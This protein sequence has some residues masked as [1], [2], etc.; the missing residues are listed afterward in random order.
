M[1][2]EPNFNGTSLSASHIGQARS[3][4]LASLALTGLIGPST[5]TVGGVPYFNDLVGGV[6]DAVS[7]R[8]L[9]DV[10]A[11]SVVGLPLNARRLVIGEDIG[12]ERVRLMVQK[13]SVDAAVT[14]VQVEANQILTANSASSSIGMQM[15]VGPVIPTGISCTGHA[16]SLNL[17]AQRSKAL[18][19]GH[20]DE[21]R[22][23]AV[24]VGGFNGLA[25]DTDC[26]E[27]I[28][29]A[30]LYV[31]GTFVDARAIYIKA[32]VLGATITRQWAIQCQDP[33]DSTLAGS[34]AVGDGVG[35]TAAVAEAAIEVNSTTQGILQARMTTA[36]KNALTTEGLIVYD[37]TL[38][39]FY[40]RTDAAWVALH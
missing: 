38:K 37:A 12:G 3:S 25:A 31:T 4:R 26:A 15:D 34:L 16:T 14:A 19:A 18:D 9:D 5:S 22:G 29:I 17:S 21:L 23:L 35:A 13:S 39:A 40:G 28:H 33:G 6:A 24:S 1:A 36:Q 8:V 30:N 32:P 2:N 7:I 27:A 20:L 11:V 10:P